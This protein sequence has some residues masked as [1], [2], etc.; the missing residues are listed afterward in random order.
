MFVFLTKLTRKAFVYRPIDLIM[1]C[2]V[3]VKP[4]LT[5]EKTVS[6]KYALMARQRELHWL[7]VW[8]FFAVKLKVTK[9]FGIN[10]SIDFSC[11]RL[12]GGEGRVLWILSDRDFCYISLCFL[13]KALEIFMG[14]EFCSHPII[15][16]PEIRSSYL[17]KVALN[18]NT[19]LCLFAL[20][21]GCT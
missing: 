13:F 9:P 5:S 1:S 11:R 15:P 10:F 7:L 3:H 18:S 6:T 21:W 16:S 17:G 8:S 20:L 14:F 19:Q 4:E 2:I 12:G